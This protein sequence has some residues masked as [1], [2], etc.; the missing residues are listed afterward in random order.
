MMAAQIAHILHTPISEI[1]EME[2]DD[3]LEWNH[4][5]VEIANK[6]GL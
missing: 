3:F 4:Q 1:M 5:A 6:R 2:L